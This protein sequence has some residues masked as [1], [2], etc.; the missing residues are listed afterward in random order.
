MIPRNN[1]L[2]SA[3]LFALVSVVALAPP[4][5]AGRPAAPINDACIA[6]GV[7]AACIR[8][9]SF[10]GSGEDLRL[11]LANKCTGRETVC[12]TDVTLTGTFNRVLIE[13]ANECSD[14]ATCTNTVHIQATIKHL[15]FRDKT[16]SV[17]GE[18]FTARCDATASCANTP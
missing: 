17:N 6:A 18:T 8:V 12:S 4:A 14:Y 9:T 15:Q 11:V 1:F 13:R 7:G 5:S 2:V 16:L 10:A 3:I